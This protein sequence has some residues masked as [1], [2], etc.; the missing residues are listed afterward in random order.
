[1]E[2]TLKDI[3]YLEFYEQ[4]LKNKLKEE[5]KID[6]EELLA[7]FMFFEIINIKK[8]KQEEVNQKAT[9]DKIK[10]LVE[11]YFTKIKK[12][13][14]NVTIE[15]VKYMLS[16]FKFID[17]SGK[18]NIKDYLVQA[19]IKNVEHYKKELEK[20][21]GIKIDENDK[22]YNKV[23]NAFIFAKKA[24]LNEKYKRKTI[25]KNIS[26]YRL[27]HI[28]EKYLRYY[29]SNFFCCK[30]IGR[31]DA[32]ISRQAMVYVMDL[33]GFEKKKDKYGDYYFNVSNKIDKWWYL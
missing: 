30:G 26:D 7:V 18:Y 10:I 21:I 20:I 8:Y 13:K 5:P 15:A 11:D 23:L 19:K 1:M 33:L 12:I 9:A 28:A 24:K 17:K 32:Y 14:I 31:R 4:R 16:L 27:K 29:L 22:F 6:F 3:P 25:N 2:R